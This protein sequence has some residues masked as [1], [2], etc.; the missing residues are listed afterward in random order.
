M[1]S[2][3]KNRRPFVAAGLIVLAVVA[4]IGAVRV[5]AEGPTYN[6]QQVENWAQ[7]PAGVKWGVMSGVSTDS[8]GMTWVLQRETPDRGDLSKVMAFDKQGKLVKSWGEKMF[9][10]AHGL[11]IDRDDN[12]W[13]TDLRSHQVMK[14]TPDGKL[15]LELGKKGVA[16]D[17]SST[18]LLNGPS[19]LVFGANGDIFISDGESSSTRVVRYSKDGKLVKFWGTKGT[20]PGEMNVPH[21]IAMDSKGQVYVADRS[22]AR[23]QIF[24]QEGKFIDQMINVGSPYGLFIAKD[25]LFV[26]DGRN[27]TMTVLTTT[28][29]YTVLGRIE[30]L[31][32]PHGV[33]VDQ[34]GA[35]LV[36]EQGLEGPGP[37]VRKF[38]KK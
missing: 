13:V 6:F 3:A 10:L 19:D 25:E 38:V 27:R 30:N 4:A 21:S 33:T 5:G 11:R 15:L 37:A 29:P 16:G 1:M 2:E 8:K 24:D 12:V 7:L 35:V 9:P 20:G 34:N 22:N 32:V 14:F 28:K 23:V 17:N 26:V 18:D 31:N 36:A